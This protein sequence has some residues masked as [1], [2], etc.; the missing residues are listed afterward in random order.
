MA[1][2]KRASRNDSLRWDLSG[3]FKLAW[4]AAGKLETTGRYKMDPPVGG[5]RRETAEAEQRGGGGHS[6]W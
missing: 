2:L 1:M 5:E 6:S 3:V 4:M